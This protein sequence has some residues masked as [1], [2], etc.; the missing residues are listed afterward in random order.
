MN[1]NHH[2][3]HAVTKIIAWLALIIAILAL[4]LAWTAY[5]RTGA[6]LDD[7]IES[8]VEN[9][10]NALDSAGDATEDATKDTLQGIEEAAG[11]AADEIDTNET[12]STQSQQYYFRL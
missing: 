8:G 11:N 5:D 6:D 2:E 4:A 1:D 10:D 9:T 12:D 3:S 7:Q